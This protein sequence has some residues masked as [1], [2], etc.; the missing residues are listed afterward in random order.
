[1]PRLPGGDWI[2]GVTIGHGGEPVLSAT[3]FHPNRSGQRG[4]A[5]AIAAAH[6]DVFR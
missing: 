3:T 6:R 2:H 5:D 1:M 4:Y